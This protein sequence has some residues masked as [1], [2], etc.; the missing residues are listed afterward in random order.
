MG[1]LDELMVETHFYRAMH[2]LTVLAWK[3]G[4]TVEALL[5]MT[6]L[7]D[8]QVEEAAAPCTE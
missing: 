5:T 8:I 4:L 6:E 3:K 2:E 7:V 1:L